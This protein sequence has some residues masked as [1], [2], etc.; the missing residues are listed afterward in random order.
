MSSVA[1][2]FRVAQLLRADG[3]GGCGAVN[4]RSHFHEYVV[5]C[6]R[7]LVAEDARQGV[8]RKTLGGLRQRDVQTCLSRSDDA[9]DW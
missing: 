6:G 7:F 9:S 1:N 4:E 3:F 5:I 2:L 8:Q